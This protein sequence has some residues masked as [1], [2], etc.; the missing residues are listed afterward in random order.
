MLVIVMM[1]VSV[2]FFFILCWGS[3][4]AVLYDSLSLNKK[5][6]SKWDIYVIGHLSY[7]SLEFW[8]F[9]DE[10]STR[11]LSSG[12]NWWSNHLQDIKVLK[13]RLNGDLFYLDQSSLWVLDLHF[14]LVNLLV[15]M[16]RT[17]IELGVSTLLVSSLERER[18]GVVGFYK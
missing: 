16:V 14:P 3:A 9:T 2:M 4:V 7:G 17:W 18:K 10:Y 5:F 11:W 15:T 1:V 6:K 12:F 13:R 8:S